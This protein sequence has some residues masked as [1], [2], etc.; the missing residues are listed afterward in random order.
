[1]EVK[2]GLTNEDEIFQK[3]HEKIV[4]II[5]FWDLFRLSLPGRI[6]VVKTLLLPQL[7]YLGCI[8]TPSRDVL[9]D[10][11]KTI[12]NFALKNL[13]VAVERKYLPANHGGLGLINLDTYLNAQKCSWIARATKNCIDNWRFDLRSLAPDGDISRIRPMDLNRQT[14]PILHNLVS[15]FTG[16]VE[17]HA[18]QNGNYWLSHIFENGA[19]R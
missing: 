16:L 2:N 4:G 13:R 3:I 18:K 11:Q 8:L 5:R 9:T 14:N 12:D 1:M 15:A 10:L 17:N 7:N 6:S 19:F